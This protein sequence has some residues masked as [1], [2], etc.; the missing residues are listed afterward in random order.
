MAMPG[1]RPA[2]ETR[3]KPRTNQRF[4]LTPYFYLFYSCPIKQPGKLMTTVMELFAGIFHATVRIVLLAFQQVLNA[5]RRRLVERWNLLHGQQS[6]CLV[7]YK[8]Q[9][10]LF[11]L[12]IIQRFVAARE[13]NEQYVVVPLFLK[14]RHRKGN[15][16]N[17]RVSQINT[18]VP[19]SS[20][21]HKVL[22]TGVINGNDRRMVQLHQVFYFRL[23][24]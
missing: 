6:H 14:L 10:F 8:A 4:I 13:D 23:E 3:I 22:E 15:I 18:A 9:V 1:S 21:H 5:S 12:K 19:D 24:T 16:A 17:R 2:A 20:Q 7:I 11:Q